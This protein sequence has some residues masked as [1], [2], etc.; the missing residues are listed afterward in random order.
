MSCSEWVTGV[1]IELSQTLVWTAKNSS[2]VNIY[3]C[4]VTLQSPLLPPPSCVQKKRC[5]FSGREKAGETKKLCCLLHTSC[6]SYIPPIHCIHTYFLFMICS[7]HCQR[8]DEPGQKIHN[9]SF[10]YLNNWKIGGFKSDHQVMPLA[11][12]TNLA[13]TPIE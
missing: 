2:E 8:H 7:K 10:F 13:T 12:V 1:G 6:I 11:F 5:I 9:S 4:I 3:F